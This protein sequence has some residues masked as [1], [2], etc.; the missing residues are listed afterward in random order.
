MAIVSEEMFI[1]FIIL[2]K[3]H[4]TPRKLRNFLLHLK[5]TSH[6]SGLM[7]MVKASVVHSE[8]FRVAFKDL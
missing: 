3:E 7:E 6:F 8:N 1:I 4:V 2:S 5:Y